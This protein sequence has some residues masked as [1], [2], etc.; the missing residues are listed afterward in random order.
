M[1]I[2]FT[3][4][5]LES[6]HGG[7]ENQT[8]WL[9]A[10]LRERGHT[11]SFLGSCPVLRQTFAA[12][13]FPVTPFEI[14]APPVTKFGAVCFLWRRSAMFQKLKAAYESL[15]EL[16]DAVCMLSL[17]EKILL[18]DWLS[19]RGVN[20]VWIEHDRVGRWLTGSPWLSSLK[21]AAKHATIVCVSELSRQKYLD[22]GFDS[23]RIIAIP[24]GIPMPET[25]NV[26]RAAAATLMVG[27]VARLSPEKGLDVLI[28]AVA[29]LPEATLRIVGKGPQEGFLRSLIAED[30]A[31]IGIPR[32]TLQSSV[33]DLNLF[34]A[35]LDVFVLASADHD[36]F[37]LT[38][39]EAMARGIPTIVTDECGIASSLTDGQD[40]LCVEAG[41]AESLAAAIRKLRDPAFRKRLSEAAEKTA[42][43]CFGLARMTTAYEAL[44]SRH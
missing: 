4:F 16:P 15:P 19:S 3:R 38:A 32:I 1:R 42:R 44:L 11:V 33:P 31:R 5:P 2:H 9:A 40:A 26:E 13:G 35:S 10:G 30:T 22:L 21:A 7:A 23:T 8:M 24:N 18:T 37:G 43:T 12:S 27:S 14:G 28:A 39:A 6:A 36:P 17:S 20:V 41:S 34:Y 25:P 29:G